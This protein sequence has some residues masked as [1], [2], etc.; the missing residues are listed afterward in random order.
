MIGTG[1]AA[2]LLGVSPMGNGLRGRG[3]LQPVATMPHWHHRCMEIALSHGL[4]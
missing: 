4:G 2:R 1:Q 3:R